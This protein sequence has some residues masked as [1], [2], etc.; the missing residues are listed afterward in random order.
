[1]GLTIY[2]MKTSIKNLQDIGGFHDLRTYTGV[3][4]KSGKPALPT[5]AIL[6][7]YMR[8]N[9]RD[10]LVSDLKKLN[11]RKVQLRGRLQDV[12]KEMTKLLEKATK[13]AMEIRGTSAKDDSLTRGLK[14]KARLVLRY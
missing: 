9:E 2:T 5:T 12:E 14:R 8:R 13:T 6:D 4:R 11:K 3:V 1:M 7:L 10:R